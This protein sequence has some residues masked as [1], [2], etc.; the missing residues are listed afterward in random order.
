MTIDHL[1]EYGPGS[2]Q[3]AAR[4]IRHEEDEEVAGPG[5]LPGADDPAAQEPG[6][7]E[8]H[9]ERRVHR[10]DGAVQH[11]DRHRGHDQ[12]RRGPDGRLQLRARPLQAASMVG[13]TVLTEASAGSFSGTQ[14]A[15]AAPSTCPM[16]H[17]PPWSASTAMPANCCASCRSARREAGLSN[18]SWDGTMSNGQP[19]PAGRYKLT[20]AI[21][22]PCRR[23]RTYHLSRVEG[24]ERDALGRRQR[25]TNPDRQRRQRA[26][27]PGQGSHVRRI[28]QCHSR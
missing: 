20:A 23:H 28:Q 13:R 8:A 25:L 16:A 14:A 7:A 4:V 3:P 19:A 10:P 12:V 11:R 9:G 21:E 18:F 6:P 26:P 22:K 24:R 1:H 17:R 5:G 2:R 15:R 27:L